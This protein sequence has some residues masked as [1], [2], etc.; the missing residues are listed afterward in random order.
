VTTSTGGSRPVLMIVHSYYE[1]DPRVRR[2][3]ETLVARGRS[4][5]VIGLRRRD[6]PVDAVVGGV[7]VRH[8][9]VQR[10]QGAG[11]GVYLA[12]YLSF[13]L[14]TMWTAARLHRSERFAV[15]QVHSPPDFLVFATLPLRLVGVPVV[16]DL[17]EAMPE[18]FRTRFPHTRNPLMH[19]LL[20]LQERLSIAFS[21][22][23]V[24]V[25]Q[26]MADRLMALGMASGKLQVVINSPSLARFDATAYPRRSF[27]ED[28]GLR[29]VYTGALTPVYELDVVLRAMARLRTSRPDI[30]VTLDLYGR[31]DSEV[32]LRALADELGIAH[33]VKFHGRI[34]LDAVPAVLAGA[35]VALAPTRL[36]RFTALTVSGKVYEAAA[37][38]KPVVAT[39][40]P[41]V[42]HDF[43]DGAVATYAS[44]D[45]EGLAVAL[46][47]LVDDPTA[48]ERSVARASEVVK[49]LA[50]EN[51]ARGY[52][53]L[54]DRL[55]E[56]RPRT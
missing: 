42:E 21:T 34:P 12:E 28:G 54:I 13:L 40:L 41:T 17:H 6:D 39:S 56:D 32:L 23:T 38:G 51:A 8:L 50:W 45:F 43:P 7:R 52:V 47:R 26:A 4:V 49:A 16:L 37:M 1:E 18:F 22:A 44:G 29:L 10:H 15:A 35:D 55:A 25:T 24:T 48:R 5:Q 9:D 14:R 30:N 36:D 11:I 31:G 3:A 53:A 46:L 33:R 20:R 2:Q 19:G 27:R